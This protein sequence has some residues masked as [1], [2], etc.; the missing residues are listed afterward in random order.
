MKKSPLFYLGF[1]ISAW[2]MFVSAAS[3]PIQYQIF[4]AGYQPSIPLQERLSAKQ[5]EFFHKSSGFYVGASDAM[6]PDQQNQSISPTHPDRMEDENYR[7]D[8]YVGIKK[9]V[10]IFGYHLGLKSYNRT[11][12]HAISREM[13]VQEMYIGGNIRELYLSYATN[14]IGEYTQLNLSREISN[15]KLGFHLG[16][17]KPLIG[18]EFVDWSLHASKSIEELTVNAILTQSDN[19]DNKDMQ[20]NIG[21]ER[22]FSFF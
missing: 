20:F 15:M 16:K 9:R 22:Q 21:I 4:D 7:V 5:G 8:A 2:P 3:Y 11:I 18:D 1:S 19:P 17:T 12:E 10:G 14:S 6:I 13:E